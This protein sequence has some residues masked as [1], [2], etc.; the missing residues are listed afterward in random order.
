MAEE[1]KEKLR[2]LTEKEVSDLMNALKNGLDL[3]IAK[4]GF[5]IEEITQTHQFLHGLVEYLNTVVFGV[6][7]DAD[8][9]KT[10]EDVRKYVQGLYNA[11]QKAAKNG[12]YTLDVGSTLYGVFDSL[13]LYFELQL[14]DK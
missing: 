13:K 4:G 7:D 6:E 10:A 1:R 12:G 8:K 9:K 2:N 11:I 3:G 14:E 5:S